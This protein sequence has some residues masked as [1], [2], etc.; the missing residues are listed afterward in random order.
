GRRHRACAGEALRSGRHHPPGQGRE[1]GAPPTW[2]TL[3][4]QLDA[5]LGDRPLDWIFPKHPEPAHACNASLLLDKYPNARIIGDLRDLQLYFPSYRAASST[6]GLA[7]SST[8]VAAPASY[9]W[10]LL[11]G[12][13]PPPFGRTSGRARRYS[14]PTASHTPTTRRLTAPRT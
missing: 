12:T 1:L 2:P 4:G 5:L 3:E 7:M 10:R 13:C 11:S 9:S 8:W 6:S 14:S